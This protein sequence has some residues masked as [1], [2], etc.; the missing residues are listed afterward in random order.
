M[1]TE[2]PTGPELGA[3]PVMPNV[4]VK[5]TPLLGRS[6]TDTTTFAFPA[7][8]PTGTGTVI[9]ESL[10]VVGVATKELKSTVLAP[11][12]APKL[13]PVI[14]TD[15]PVG[16]EVGDRLLIAGAIVKNPGLTMPPADT[17]TGI[18]PAG[19]P[20]GTGTTIVVLLQL[21]G[22]AAMPL[23]VT[24]LAPWVAPKPNPVMVTDVPTCP[25]TGESV[26]FGT[27]VNATLLLAVVM[28]VTSMKSVP[29][30]AFTTLPVILVL[31]QLVGV[32]VKPLICTRL[33]P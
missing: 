17:T 1:V 15:V 30:G 26:I 6:P 31:L 21:V 23:N 3:M 14:V 16:P 18:V 20:P 24:V 10:Q 29:R 4:T 11:R 22:V 27:T 28:T 5:I 9:L 25:V 13:V 7:L 2:V 12:V 19:T 8:T 33:V 32:I